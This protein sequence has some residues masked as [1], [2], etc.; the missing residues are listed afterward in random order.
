[1]TGKQ[2]IKDVTKASPKASKENVKS[3]SPSPASWVLKTSLDSIWTGSLNS[4]ALPSVCVA[5]LMGQPPPVP[6]AFLG[7][8]S[9]VSLSVNSHLLQTEA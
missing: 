9:V 2:A 1:M 4:E 6:T 7:S 5:S 3:V 8:H